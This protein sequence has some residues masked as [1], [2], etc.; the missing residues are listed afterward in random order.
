MLSVRAFKVLLLGLIGSAAVL[1]QTT[2]QTRPPLVIRSTAGPDLFAFY[3]SS[4]HGRDGTGA[5]RSPA[6]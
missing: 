6:R 4:C 1:A 5:G 3:C 2:G